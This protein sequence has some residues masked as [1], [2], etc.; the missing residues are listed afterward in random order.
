MEVR[1]L[2]IELTLEEANGIREEMIEIVGKGVPYLSRLDAIIEGVLR[3]EE[4]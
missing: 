4:H 2:V 1:S 3:P